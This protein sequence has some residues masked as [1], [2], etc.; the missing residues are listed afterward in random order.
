MNRILPEA[1]ELVKAWEGFHPTPYVD[2]GGGLTIGYG[3][4]SIGPPEVKADMKWTPEEAEA[5]LMT[6]LELVGKRLSKELKVAVNDYQWGALLSLAYNKGAGRLIRSEVW[7]VMHDRTI[8][9]NMVKAGLKILDFAVTAEDKVTKQVR[10][11]V[12]LRARRVAEAALFLKR[13]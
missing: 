12:G 8:E 13:H 5:Y 11:F 1:L 2:T 4:S 3:H 9:Y 6:D 10:E 7:E